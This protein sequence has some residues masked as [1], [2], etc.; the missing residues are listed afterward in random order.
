MSD[1]DAI[2]SLLDSITPEAELP[3]A[4][5]RRDLREQAGLSKAQVAR[6][7]GVGPSTVAGWEAGRDPAGQTRT[8]YAYLL[9]GLAAKLT[10]PAAPEADETQPPAA[11]ET[12][13][14]PTTTDAA[15]GDDVETL[16]VPEPCVLCGTP[17]TQRVAGF[18]QHL[19]PADCHTTTP[20]RTAPTAPQPA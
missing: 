5:V 12:P 9:D 2:D 18:P 3:E 19:N 11:Q 6:T 14:P 17:A 13:P 15:D 8:R 20:E 16:T 4:T 1:F 7:L 10:P